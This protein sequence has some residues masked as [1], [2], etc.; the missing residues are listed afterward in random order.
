MSPTPAG[1]PF[2][3]LLVDDSSIA[4]DM[5]RASLGE[6]LQ[7]EGRGHFELVDLNDGR[8]VLDRLG[9]ERFDL[10]LLDWVLPKFSGAE[11]LKQVRSDAR[12]AR[13]PVVVVSTAPD[14]ARVQALALGANAFVSK[15]VINSRLTEALHATLSAKG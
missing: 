7:A 9:K 12:F 3:V 13:L 15:P 2:R 5:L 10:L 6:V 1:Q 11:V 4:R 14:E 8:A